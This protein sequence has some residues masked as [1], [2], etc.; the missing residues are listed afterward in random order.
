MADDVFI[1]DERSK[2]DELYIFSTSSRSGRDALAKLQEAFAD[3]REH[4]P[5]EAHLLPLVTLSGDHYEHQEFGRIETPELDIGGWV[6]PP[7]GVKQLR[8]PASASP[9]LAIEYAGE[10]A[11]KPTQE[12]KR[13]ELDDEIPF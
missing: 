9:L 5:K 1:A 11:A 8:P 12:P 3:H 4:H 2:S 6:E 7:L 10:S 13:H